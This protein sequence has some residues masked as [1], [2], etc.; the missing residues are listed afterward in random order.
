MLDPQ[1]DPNDGEK[2]EDPQQYVG[3]CD[4][5]AKQDEPHDYTRSWDGWIGGRQGDTRTQREGDRQRGI[6]WNITRGERWHVPLAKMVNG[7][8][9]SLVTR[10]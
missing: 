5:P 4:D 10:W 8:K 6:S 9:G 2:E 3:R 1:S 7:W